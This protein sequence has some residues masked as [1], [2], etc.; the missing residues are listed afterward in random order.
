MSRKISK[1]VSWRSRGLR[2]LIGLVA[3]PL[4]AHAADVTNLDLTFTGLSFNDRLRTDRGPA[5]G[6]AI[7][8]NFTP[9]DS[10]RQDFV[11]T[12]IPATVAH[13]RLRQMQRADTFWVAPGEIALSWEVVFE[14]PRLNGILPTLGFSQGVS[15]SSGDIA[16]VMTV[17]TDGITEPERRRLL[18]L[19][20]TPLSVGAQGFFNSAYFLDG[21]MDVGIERC[22]EYQKGFNAPYDWPRRLDVDCERDLARKL[23]ASVDPRVT[24]IPWSV[25]DCRIGITEDTGFKVH[26][27]DA[28][29]ADIRSKYPGLS[30]QPL[31]TETHFRVV[32]GPRYLSRPLKH[33]VESDEC[34]RFY[35]GLTP[36]KS[37]EESIPCTDEDLD[38]IDALPLPNEDCES[39][40]AP[41]SIEE[42]D[43]FASKCGSGLKSTRPEAGFGDP[44]LTRLR[45]TWMFQVPQIP[46]TGT[47]A[48]TFSDE[49]RAREIRI[50]VERNGMRRYVQAHEVQRVS[51]NGLD[52]EIPD[53]VTPGLVPTV[54]KEAVVDMSLCIE[55]ENDA[56]RTARNLVANPTWVDPD[57]QTLALWEVTLRTYN[58]G[59]TFDRGLA[60]R[61]GERAFIE[62]MMVQR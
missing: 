11:T 54:T 12:A 30:H 1:R 33:N 25:M 28:R 49:L 59:G 18:L 13:T 55:N 36:F 4:S 20:A 3:F 52:C 32:D 46:T 47:L 27:T 23:C 43:K 6:T 2:L 24:Q 35:G 37:A 5:H 31:S 17:G 8:P 51:V 22:H 40:E 45:S 19:G 38:E 60:I 29:G 14:N 16:R 61:S 7:S 26:V 53:G 44:S 48:E 21:A 10:S 50:F 9:P 15:V 42:L 56:S 34:D 62:F 39:A 58:A 41:R 57:P